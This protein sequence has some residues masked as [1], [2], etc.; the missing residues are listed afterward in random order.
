MSEKRFFKKEYEEQYYI[1]DSETISEKDF[2]ERY[3][4]DGYVA[5]EDSMQGDEVVDKLN[6]QQDTIFEQKIAIDEM[7]TDYKNLEKENEKLRKSEKINM[8]YAKQIVD[9]NHKLR[10]AKN[11]LR[12]ENEK[13]K[14][15]LKNLNLNEKNDVVKMIDGKAF[16]RM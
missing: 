9:E 5:F 2:D 16:I 3:E 13:L 14:R 7:I 10:I 15:K 12:I 11:D 1:F 6:E 8:E 4:Y